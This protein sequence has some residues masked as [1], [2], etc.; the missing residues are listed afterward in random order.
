MFTTGVTVLLKP[1]I[2]SAVA[3]IALR[4]RTVLE[5]A[6]AR[7]VSPEQVAR[8]R[9]ENWLNT[10]TEVTTAFAAA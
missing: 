4:L 5:E 7:S 2:D 3:A 8:E 6:R 9:A 1:D 10:R